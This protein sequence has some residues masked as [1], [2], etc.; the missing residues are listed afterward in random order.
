[1]AARGDVLIQTR[2]AVLDE[3]KQVVA[4]GGYV[5]IA[6]FQGERQGRIAGLA[7]VLEQAR[8]TGG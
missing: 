8:K 1:M 5:L 2:V 7:L 4:D 3:L 6:A